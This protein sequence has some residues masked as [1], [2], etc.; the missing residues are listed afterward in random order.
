MSRSW[1]APLTLAF[2]RTEGIRCSSVVDERSAAFIALGIAE[3]TRKPVVLVYFGHGGTQFCAGFGR[4]VLPPYPA[5]GAYA[6]PPQRLREPTRRPN[7]E[8]NRRV[9][10]LHPRKFPSQRRY[11]HGRRI[12]L[13]APNRQCGTDRATAAFAVRFTSTWLLRNPCTVWRNPPH[14]PAAFRLAR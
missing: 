7:D 8:L 11:P 4:S 12:G 6:D 14:P 5:V 13:L 2:S 10:Q 9:C 3:T 1:C